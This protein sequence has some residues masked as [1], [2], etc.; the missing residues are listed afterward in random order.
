VTPLEQALDGQGPVRA[1]AAGLQVMA[2]APLH[3]GELP[4]MVDQELADLIHPAL[5]PAKACIPRP[6]DAQE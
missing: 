1:A 5:T 3:G 2:S 4:T 6:R